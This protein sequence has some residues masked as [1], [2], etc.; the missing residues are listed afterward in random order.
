MNGVELVDV[1]QDEVERF[2]VD[3]ADSRL[4]LDEVIAWLIDRV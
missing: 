1:A 4:S 3:V 2:M